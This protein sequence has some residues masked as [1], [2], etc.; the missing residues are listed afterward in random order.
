MEPG[1]QT[2]EHLLGIQ[3]ELI[4]REPIFHRPEYGTS[5]AHFEAMMADEFWETSASG[6]RYSRDYVLEVLETRY[7]NGPYQDDWKT[8]DFHC[9]EIALDNYLLTYTLLQGER[10]T[11][12]AT[13]W[14]RSDN[15]WV[16]V[17]HQGT[18]VE[19]K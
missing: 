3:K 10:V 8:E 18:V 15:G 11:R 17:Y 5:R 14:R 4:A 16:I 7:A 2:E 9:Q 12:R 1:R 6:Q 19:R 13:L